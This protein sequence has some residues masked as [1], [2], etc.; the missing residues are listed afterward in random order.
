MDAAGVAASSPNQGSPDLATTTGG[1]GS[2]G[3]TGGFGPGG[4]GR[5]SRLWALG[6]ALLLVV[7]IIVGVAV[8]E[9]GSSGAQVS[10]RDGPAL[11]ASGSWALVAPAD[12]VG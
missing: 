1:G 5:R 12:L 8:S 6:G 4:K 11:S 3:P 7:G 9:G 2:G 10:K